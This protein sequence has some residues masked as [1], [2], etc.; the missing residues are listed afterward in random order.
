[1][2]HLCLLLSPLASLVLGCGADIEPPPVEAIP[3]VITIQEARG[4]AFGTRV[5]VAGFVSVV[6]GTFLSSTGDA[7]FAIQDDTGGIY[8][9]LNTF[10]DAPQNAKMEVVGDVIDGSGQDVILTNLT[11]T[12]RIFEDKA[13]VPQD[14]KTSE[15]GESTEGLI[16][17]VKGTVTKA[18]VDNKP[19]GFKA[20]VDDGSGEVQIFIN[21]VNNTPLI[22]TAKL[23]VGATV[24]I[25]GYSSQFES[26]YEVLPRRST[27]LVIP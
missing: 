3:E 21:L 7:G 15:I 9:T 18:V 22:D 14:F 8:I 19:Y 23:T 5:H 16:V 13:V 12:K 27:D 11:G 17:R 4:S 20:F 24:Q 25:T 2:R 6:Q 26:T 10:L 1:M